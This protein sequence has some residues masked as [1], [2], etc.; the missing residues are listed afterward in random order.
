MDP[1]FI[2][3]YY[4]DDLFPSESQGVE[5]GKLL[6]SKSVR[7]LAAVRRRAL[8]FQQSL[9]EGLWVEPRPPGA[10]PPGPR[11]EFNYLLVCFKSSAAS[12]SPVPE[13]RALM[14]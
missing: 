4:W 1:P 5:P 3:F 2:C 12:G 11:C 9:S 10:V 7:A 14:C 8:V 13:E 6:L